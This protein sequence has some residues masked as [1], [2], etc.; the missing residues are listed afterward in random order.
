MP[1]IPVPCPSLLQA[2]Y[3]VLTSWSFSTALTCSWF[4]IVLTE[5]SS[6]VTLGVVSVTGSGIESFRVSYWKPLIR[7]Y[8]WPILPPWS[9]AC[10]FAL[11][12]VSRPV[13]SMDGNMLREVLT[14]QSAPWSRRP[15]RSPVGIK[16]DFRVAVA[17][18]AWCNIQCRKA[19]LRLGCSC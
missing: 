12:G 13:H 19:W 8:S 5:P 18:S 7:E 6:K 9:V 4:S 11:P 1:R 16:S 14:P 17:A 15:C 3:C 2:L 10:F